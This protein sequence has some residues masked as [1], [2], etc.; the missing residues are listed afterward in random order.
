[1]RH[2][3]IQAKQ[4]KTISPL[5]HMPPMV[6]N[7]SPM[8]IAVAPMRHTLLI[9]LVRLEPTGELLAGFRMLVKVVP[10]STKL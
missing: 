7:N 4:I 5:N 10:L 6:H 8:C 2:A 3:Y 1:M 9:G